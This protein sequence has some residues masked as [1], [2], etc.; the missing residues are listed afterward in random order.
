MEFSI[1]TPALLFP[2]ISLLMLGF[3]NRFLAVA[4]LIRQHIRL[5]QENRDENILGQIRNFQKRLRII[6][7]TQASGVTSF[8]FCTVSMFFVFLRIQTA[9]EISFILSLVT[10]IISL[11]LSLEEIFLSIGALNIEMKGI[12]DS[13]EGQAEKRHRHE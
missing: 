4:A 12:Q 8:L 2:A 3:T 5:Y 9:A 11:L 13:S 6:K 7:Y 10:M 1:S